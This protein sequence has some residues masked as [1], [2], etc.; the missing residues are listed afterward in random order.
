MSVCWVFYVY[1]VRGSVCPFGYLGPGR[2]WYCFT[3]WYV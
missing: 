3:L 1:L 2:W